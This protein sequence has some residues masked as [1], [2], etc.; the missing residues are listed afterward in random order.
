MAKKSGKKSRKGK[1]KVGIKEPANNHEKIGDATGKPPKAIKMNVTL[2]SQHG[3]WLK[4]ETYQVPQQVPNSSARN[5]V[6]SG[7]AA[8]VSP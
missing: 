7:A 3:S 2:S 1:I 5:W 6:R 4:D 8:D